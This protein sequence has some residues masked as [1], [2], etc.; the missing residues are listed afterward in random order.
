MSLDLQLKIEK[1]A[2][3]SGE[4][5]VCL[6]GIKNSGNTPT[7]LANPL[8]NPNVPVLRVVDV[9]TGIELLKHGKE[10]HAGTVYQPV[11][12]GARIEHEFSL[13]SIAP[14]TVPGQYD[15]S[16]IVPHEGG[17]KRAESDPVRVEVLPV[18]PRA[19]ALVHVQGC[20]AAIQYAVSV[21]AAS[22][23]PQVVRFQ[24]EVMSKGGVSDARAVATS[25]LRVSPA[26]SAP[27]N[28]HVAHSHWIAWIE[29]GSLAYTH[30]DPLQ[31]ALKPG[32]WKI[33]EPDAV[34]VTPLVSEAVPDSGE[35][36]PGSALLWVGDAAQNVSAFQE[37]EFAPN[38]RARPGGRCPVEGGQPEWMMAHARSD[39][40]KLVSYVSAREDGAS[41]FFR[42]FPAPN[43]A[44]QPGP[45]AVW[46]GECLAGGALI[47]EKD[48]IQGAVLI[49]G[50]E[51]QGS[52]LQLITWRLNE[53]NEYAERNRH[54]IPWDHANGLDEVLVRVGP[55]GFAAVLLRNP[56]GLWTYFDINVGKMALPGGVAASP[57]PLDLAFMGPSQVVLV[58]GQLAQGFKLLTLDGKPLPPLEG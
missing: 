53:D 47:S 48:E 2:I 12:A 34:L 32:R 27:R 56:A 39:G 20:W 4:N 25:S 43:D 29:S 46:N 3:L 38:G 30:Y 21:N 7:T 28:L 13:N 50:P 57:L 49:Q 19:F 31:G 24:L 16:A 5:P 22:D 18:T 15:I 44:R 58:S 33:P 23:P 26:L 35:R 11:D 42:P 45:L 55:T 9:K 14:L 6:L 37:V 40:K 52:P 36:P 54:D 10:R 41:L 1:S 51:R 8:F 17:L